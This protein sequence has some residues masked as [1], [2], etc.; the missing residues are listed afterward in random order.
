MA[1]RNVTFQTRTNSPAVLVLVAITCLPEILLT[2]L[3]T[4]SPNASQWRMTAI[5]YG[6]FWNGLLQGW[7]PL[8]LFQRE[9]MFASYAFLHGGLMHLLGNMVAVLALGGIVV[10]RIGQKGFLLLYAISAFGGAAGFALLSGSETPMVGAS[11]AVFGLIGAWKFWEWQARQHF[12]SPMRP[13]WSSLIGLVILN[14]VLWVLLS[15]LLAWEAHL[16]GFLA[17]VLF[18]AIVTPTLRY[19]V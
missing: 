3:G 4:I 6:A 7:E 1:P 5:A 13:L 9:A 15:G 19:R 8:Y 2:L 17:G 16:G 14:I 10:A 12:G 11:G 18:A